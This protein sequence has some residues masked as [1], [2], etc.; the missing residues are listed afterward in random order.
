M[1]ADSDVTV[2]R[3]RMA[4]WLIGSVAGRQAGVHPPGNRSIAFDV[5][6]LRLLL[7]L[8]LLLR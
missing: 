8:L 5:V 4:G 6:L 3:W 2:E 1:I 7:L